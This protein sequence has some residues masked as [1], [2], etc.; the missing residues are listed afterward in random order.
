[1]KR[2]SG[3]GIPVYRSV[4]QVL[5]RGFEI[6]LLLERVEKAL[7]GAEV[8]DCRDS[9]RCSTR[10]GELGDLLPAATEIPAPTIITILRFL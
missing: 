1:M 10:R 6:V 3:V 9:M 4:E 8:G 2:R 5:A 7:G